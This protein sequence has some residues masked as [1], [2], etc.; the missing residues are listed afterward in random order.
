MNAP[1]NQRY[2]N[3]TVSGDRTSDAF[4]QW[5]GHEHKILEA[6][7][8]AA[9]KAKE[10][11]AAGEGSP[12]PPPGEEPH[13]LRLHR[14]GSKGVEGCSL[15][16]SLRVKRVPGNFHVQFTHESFN[17]ENSLINATHAINHLSFGT[18]QPKATRKWIEYGSIRNLFFSLPT[19]SFIAGRIIWIQ[20]KLAHSK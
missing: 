17:F 5:M 13:A 4:F 6:E 11:E 10:A 19:H 12:P 7:Q 14:R 2:H 9:A 8:K 16:G 18:P 15:E 3:C 20:S 1:L